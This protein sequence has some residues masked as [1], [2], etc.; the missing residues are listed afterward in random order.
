MQD[1][2]CTEPHSHIF[3]SSL[4]QSPC[5]VCGLHL[6]LLVSRAKRERIRL[7]YRHLRRQNAFLIRRQWLDPTTNNQEPQDM[8]IP[9]M[10]Q[11]ILHKDILSAVPLPNPNQ[12]PQYLNQE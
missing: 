5:L 8:C 10:S 6:F 1:F 2:F 7:G 11:N 12:Q 4:P 9:Q 3:Q